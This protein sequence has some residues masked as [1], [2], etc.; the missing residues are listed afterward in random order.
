MSD[1]H[2]PFRLNVQPAE[3]D[4]S[5]LSETATCGLLQQITG[6]TAEGACRVV[7]AACESCSEWFADVSIAI[8]N[9]ILL[10]YRVHGDSATQ[11][12]VSGWGTA[13]RSASQL[14][15]RRRRKL[16]R[17]GPFDPRVFGGLTNHCGITQGLGQRLR[18]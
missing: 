17:Q 4:P 14:E 1:I 7:R 9:D 15:H 11:N 3:A 10:K 18:G 13:A 8:S 6:A 5:H 16:F 12:D 2:C